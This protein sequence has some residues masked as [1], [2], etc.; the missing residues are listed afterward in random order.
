[1]KAKFILQ[2]MDCRYVID[3]QE[4]STGPGYRTYINYG[5]ILFT[6][7]VYH[8]FECCPLCHGRWSDTLQLYI[9]VSDEPLASN[10]N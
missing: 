8:G 6:H 4:W 9:D 2:C 5:S 10:D 1:M 7:G 3:E